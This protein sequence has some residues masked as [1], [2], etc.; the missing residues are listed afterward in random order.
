M[1]ISDWSS[2]VCSSDLQKRAD[3][4]HGQFLVAMLDVVHRTQDHGNMADLAERRFSRRIQPRM[5]DR[6][7]SFVSQKIGVEIVDIGMPACCATASARSNANGFA[8]DAPNAGARNGADIPEEREGVREG[9]R[10]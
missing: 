10:G 4:R 7:C 1:R 5:L 8:A 2:D 3:H 9:K 6:A